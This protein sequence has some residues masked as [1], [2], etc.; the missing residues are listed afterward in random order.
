MTKVKR[1]IRRLYDEQRD[2]LWQVSDVPTGCILLAG[3]G[4]P[5]GYL[6]CDGSA[7]DRGTYAD[8]FEA[9]GTTFGSGNGTTTF[10]VPNLADYATGVGF[11]IKAF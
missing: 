11:V 10:N 2:V 6:D 9:I 4:A 8:L 5:A 3:V 7:V 1:G